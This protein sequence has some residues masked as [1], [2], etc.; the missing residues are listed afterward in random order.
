MNLLS[1]KGEKVIFLD[2]NGYDTQREYAKKRGLVK[3]ETYTVNNTRIGRFD[4]TVNLVEFPDD[5]FNTVMFDNLN[6]PKD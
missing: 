3:E 1:K 2:E 6:P 5:W 4:S